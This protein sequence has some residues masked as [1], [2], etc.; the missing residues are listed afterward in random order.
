MVKK[1]MESKKT[2]DTK[3]EYLEH[4]LEP[5]YDEKSKVLILGS[6]PS[7][8]SRADSFYYGNPQNRFWKVVAFLTGEEVPSSTIG[9]KKLVLK[10]NIAIW[11][12]ISSCQIIGSSDSSIKDIM[13]TDIARITKSANIKAI[14]T[15]GG[16]SNK[17]YKKYLQKT[18]EI[19]AIALPSTSP[20]NARYSLEQLEKIW[21]DKIGI[22]L[23][24]E[25]FGGK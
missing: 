25:K 7:V 20:A 4:T 23:K 17:L 21:Q 3:Y 16:L 15:N 18:T 11:D 6:F 14:Y 22:Y 13:P 12:V 9:K 19:E 10:N 1:V 24:N 5:I 2:K 8:K